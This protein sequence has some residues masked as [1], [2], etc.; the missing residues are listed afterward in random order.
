MRDTHNDEG[1][2]LRDA[3]SGQHSNKQDAIISDDPPAGV[4]ETL[5]L[6]VYYPNE[7]GGAS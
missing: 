2:P 7:T 4:I 5:K 1:A 6:G 3:P